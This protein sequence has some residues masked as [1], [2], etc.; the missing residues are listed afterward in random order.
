MVVETDTYKEIDHL[1]MYAKNNVIHNFHCWRRQLQ[2][3]KGRKLYKFYNTGIGEIGM[4][5]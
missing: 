5:I 3:W 1:N 4:N 2:I